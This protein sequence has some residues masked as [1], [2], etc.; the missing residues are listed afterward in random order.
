MGVPCSHPDGRSVY[1]TVSCDTAGY[2]IQHVF[3]TVS[4]SLSACCFQWQ[5]CRVGFNIDQW[6]L[7]LKLKVL[8]A[9]DCLNNSNDL[10]SKL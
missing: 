9:F 2:F 5:M 8:P 4:V 1:V 3:A 10:L 6:V 7:V